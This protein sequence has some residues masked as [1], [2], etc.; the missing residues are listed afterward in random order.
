MTPAF[1]LACWERAATE[2]LG[3]ILTLAPGVSKRSVEKALYDAR[4]RSG[5][6]DLQALSLVL[7][8]DA[9]REVWLVRKPVDMKDVL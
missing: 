4:Q 9:E 7:P 8:G 2:E 6:P 5:N 3:L 1:A